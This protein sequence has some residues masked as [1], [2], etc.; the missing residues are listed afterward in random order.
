M[1]QYIPFDSA[2]LPFLNNFFA[3]FPV[4]NDPYPAAIPE[5]LYRMTG[6]LASFWGKTYKESMIESG[7]SESEL[8]DYYSDRSDKRLNQTPEQFYAE[9]DRTVQELG[10]DMTLIQK[11]I[12][13]FLHD[14]RVESCENSLEL[15]K[16]LD[17]FLAPVYVALRNRGYNKADLWC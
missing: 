11:T 9:V 4:G 13:I 3:H 15:S 2:E 1:G 6:H 14:S 17:E 5:G 7:L 10:M 12:N 16:I 8:Q